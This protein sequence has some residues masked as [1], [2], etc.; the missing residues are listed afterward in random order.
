MTY[1]PDGHAQPFSIVEN[2]CATHA[3]CAARDPDTF[4]EASARCYPCEQ[5]RASWDA[6]D[7]RCPANCGLG[8]ALAL[9]G[10]WPANVT[11]NEASGPP[12]S[13]IRTATPPIKHPITL[14]LTGR[15]I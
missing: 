1:N 3:D 4:C 2:A 8:L 5:C 14:P 12:S 7:A 13:S 6:V 9:G 10:S 11:E 15:L